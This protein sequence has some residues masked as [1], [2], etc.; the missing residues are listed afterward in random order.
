VEVIEDD[1]PIYAD[2]LG[3]EWWWDGRLEG[4]PGMG[5]G[6]GSDADQPD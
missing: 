2:R 4:R 1:E 5:P 3:T 6:T